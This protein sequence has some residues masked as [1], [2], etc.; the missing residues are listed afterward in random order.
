MKRLIYLL[1]VIPLLLASCS[2]NEEVAGGDTVQVNFCT[3]LPG[4]IGTRS[5]GDLNVNKVVCA[6]FENG[7]EI[8]NLRK[9]IDVAASGTIV[10]APRLIKGRTYN[11]VFWAMKDDCYNV[12]DL[13]SITRASAAS[14][15]D[16]ECFTK[17]VQVTVTGSTSETVTLTRPCAQLNL[18]VTEDDWN[19]V[20]NTFN[21]T[22]NS[23]VVKVTG[24]DTFN[25]LT[26][27]TTGSETYVT[28]TLT[29]SGSDLVVDV[30]TYKSIAMCYIYPETGQTTANITYTLNDQS[31]R[32]IRQ[33]ATIQ[34]VPLQANY[35]TNVVG[36][37]LIGTITYTITFNANFGSEG[38]NEVIQ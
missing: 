13:T 8:S 10:Y 24:K 1:L 12:T 17:A 23:I 15:S 33:D 6:V 37:L 14:E 18:G 29:V 9:V 21:M 2:N 36:G 19:T 20:A 11:I 30:T 22:P 25:A 7:T 31:N 32:V 3:E 34:N 26:G 4:R 35:R 27:K 16:Y 38:I 28:R 5:T